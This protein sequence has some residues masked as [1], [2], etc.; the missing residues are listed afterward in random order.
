MSVLMLAGI[1][2]LIIIKF[3][4]YKEK[5]DTQLAEKFPIK[6]I[7]FITNVSPSLGLLGTIY[8]LLLSLQIATPSEIP[9]FIGIALTTT[10]V[11]S[12]LFVVGFSILYFYDDT[13]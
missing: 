1:I 5:T 11:G 6:L 7:N 10:Y 12:F 3:Y 13:E 4:Y 9:R 2:S 8:G